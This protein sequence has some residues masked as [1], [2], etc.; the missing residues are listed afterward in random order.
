MD[1]ETLQRRLANGRRCYE[2][3]KEQRREAKERYKREHPELVAEQQRQASLRYRERHKSDPEYQERLRARERAR[4]PKRK[5][6]PEY[7]KLMRVIDQRFK[8][9]RRDDPEYRQKNCERQLLY[10]KT[11]KGKAVTTANSKLHF[12]RKQQAEGS[13]TTQEW[14]ELL[15]RYG[16]QCLCCGS[17][18]E[19]VP[20]H[21]IPLS[22]GGSDWISNIQ[23]LCRVCNCEKGTKT[24]DYRQARKEA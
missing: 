1:E 3:H 9:K 19:L 10:Q 8:A 23:P 16:H 22:R 5:F 13:F 17:Q 14:Q 4:W 7:R 2:K 20:D 6:D 11:A 18:S 24:I 15:A 12:L 21:V